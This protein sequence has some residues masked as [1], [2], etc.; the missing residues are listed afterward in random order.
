MK[1]L[2]K[3]LPDERVWVAIVRYLQQRSIYTQQ[4]LFT[5]D[6]TTQATMMARSQGI[7][8]GLS[9]LINCVEDLNRPVE[10]ESPDSGTEIEV[11]Y[12]K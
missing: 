4:S 9:D 3:T 5:G 1:E 2:L 8:I 12:G 6:P 11:K 10:E 7:M